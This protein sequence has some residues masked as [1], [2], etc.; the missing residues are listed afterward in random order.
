VRVA[1]GMDVDAVHRDH[2]PPEDHRLKVEPPAGGKHVRDCGEETAIDL[3][4]AAGSVL[5]GRA[6]VLEGAQA[7]DGVELTKA[8]AGDVARVVKADVE[9]VPAA[10]RRLRGGQRDTDAGAAPAADE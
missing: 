1:R 3:I 4:L 6:E 9:P 8:R 10:R 7:R 5:V 2:V